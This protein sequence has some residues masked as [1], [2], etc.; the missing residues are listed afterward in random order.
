[1]IH[2]NIPGRDPIRLVQYYPQFAAY[3]PN[4]EMATKRWW[5][6]N[7]KPDWVI[8]DC[9][10]NIGYY[11]ILF[12]QLA[13]QG[14]VYAFEPTDTVSML[15]ANLGDNGV[16]NVEVHRLAL[17]VGSGRRADSIYRIWGDEPER[18]EVDFVSI[19]DFVAAKGIAKLDAIKIDVDSFDL[20]VLLGAQQTL[21]RFDPYVVVELNHALNKRQQSNAQAFHW[22]TQQGYREAEVLEY[23]NYVLKRSDSLAA[24]YP[25]AARFELVFG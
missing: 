10:A 9:G 13:P 20:E 24:K 25:G 12:S 5:V 7:I 3:Y 1:M 4:C 18:K 16:G 19:D 17:G 23:E 6:D 21:R 22:L 15:A 8:L 14:R 2:T 11:S